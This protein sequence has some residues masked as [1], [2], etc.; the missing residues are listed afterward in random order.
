M[1]INS[2]MTVARA[3]G[4]AMVPNEEIFLDAPATARRPHSTALV[5]AGPVHR[6]PSQAARVLMIR[7]RAK[8]SS[9]R[10]AIMG[11]S[12]SSWLPNRAHA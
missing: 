1:R 9:A 3:A 4:F 2:L 8:L 7:S 11:Q 5:I 12:L 10:A 6:T